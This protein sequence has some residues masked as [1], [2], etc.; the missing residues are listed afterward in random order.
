MASSPRP[1]PGRAPARVVFRPACTFAIPTTTSSSSP[2]TIAG[3]DVPTARTSGAA[4][5]AALAPVSS[6]TKEPPTT[7]RAPH[8]LQPYRQ[9]KKYGHA[10]QRDERPP[11]RRESCH[12]EIHRAG[13]KQH[14]DYELWNETD[15]QA[16]R[17]SRPRDR[18]AVHLDSPVRRNKH[19]G[20]IRKDIA[21]RPLSNTFLHQ[22]PHESEADDPDQQHNAAGC[23]ALQA[24]VA[25]D[26]DR[27]AVASSNGRETRHE[28]EDRH[29]DD[30]GHKVGT[31]IFSRSAAVRASTSHGC[32][33]A[34]RSE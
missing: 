1:A 23:Q 9:N 6:R 10:R 18:G 34:N 28:T 24:E 12:Q 2:C 5:R 30:H 26:T 17:T 33:A 31:A 16:R 27:K 3:P 15:L 32:Q 14:R 22:R 21:E 11:C 20:R 25:H 19:S 8:P 13:E 7:C 29:D 4:R